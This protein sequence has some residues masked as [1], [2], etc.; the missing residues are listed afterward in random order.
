LLF[1]VSAPIVPLYS[2]CVSRHFQHA[3]RTLSVFHFL[4]QGFLATAVNFALSMWMPLSKEVSMGKGETQTAC[5]AFDF[6]VN[7][8]EF[9]RFLYLMS[10][11]LFANLHIMFCRH[12]LLVNHLQ[13]FSRA[14]PV[15]SLYRTIQ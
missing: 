15:Y 13:I 3:F 14:L 5:Y 9:L 7:L 8:L 12:P 10:A 11:P 4:L 1:R 6:V 2:P